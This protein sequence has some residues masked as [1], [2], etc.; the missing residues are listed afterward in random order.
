MKQIR[1]YSKKTAGYHNLDCLF[2]WLYLPGF[3]RIDRDSRSRFKCHFHCRCYCRGV[4]ISLYNCKKHLRKH[5]MESCF[6][7]P[8]LNFFQYILLGGFEQAGGTLTF[9]RGKVLTVCYSI[10]KFLPAGFKVSI[11]YIL[12]F[13]RRLFLF[14]GSVCPESGKIQTFPLNSLSVFFYWAGIYNHANGQSQGWLRHSGIS[15]V[16]G[17]GLPCPYYR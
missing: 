7:N 2:H 12:F 15:D 3:K 17:N 11:L 8:D 6:S 13:L 10:G 9:L 1:L 4:W 16:A 14:Y 5:G